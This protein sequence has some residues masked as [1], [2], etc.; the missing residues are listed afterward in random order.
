MEVRV[1]RGFFKA[2]PVLAVALL[3]GCSIKQDVRPAQLDTNAAPEICL[4]PAT[5][6]RKSLTQA[7]ARALQQ[8]GFIT[9]EL[10]EGSSN[11]RCPLAT[12]YTATWRWDLA[13]Y[14]SKARFE[15]YQNGRSVGLAEYDASWGGARL[16]KFIDAEAKVFELVDQ[17]FPVGARQLQTLAMDPPQ[18]ASKLSQAEQVRLL[19][20][21]KLTYDEY[22][23]RYR[24]IMEQ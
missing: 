8:K 16:D 22:Q 3:A 17:L 23:R 10:S 11:T 19:Q 1:Y 15:V 6:V 4:I 5:G 20:Q 7:Y 18:D 12:A 9:R 14:M 21:E 13:L 2:I 24:L